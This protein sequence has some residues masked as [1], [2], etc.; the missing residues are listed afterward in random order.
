MQEEKILYMVYFY[1][2]QIAQNC[3]FHMFWLLLTEKV[4]AKRN[5]SF[6]NPFA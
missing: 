5:G 2:K 4:E 1:L 6:S 3:K